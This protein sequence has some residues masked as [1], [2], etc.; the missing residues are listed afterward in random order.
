MADEMI[1]ERRKKGFQQI[2]IGVAL[3]IIVAVAYFFGRGPAPTVTSFAECAQKGFPIL[4]SYPRQ[5]R[6][7]DGKTFREDIGGELEK[8]NLIRV[9][10][11]RPNVSVK[12]PLTVKGV[13]R[14]NWF[15]EASFPIKLLDASGKEVAQGI[16]QAKREWMTTEFV[17]FEAVLTFTI[18][19]VGQGT[20]VLQK[21]NPSGLLENDDVLRIPI[22]FEKAPTGT[23][24]VAKACV[25]S[26]CSGQI[27]ADEEMM[28]TCEFREEY[29]CYKNAK[30]ERQTSGKC[31]WT[32]TAALR[33]CIDR[34]KR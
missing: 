27:C 34:T 18:P 5:C 26:G 4:E 22:T 8:D 13:A 3:L 7:S 14:G 10:D 25:V 21:D 23:P 32:E 29:A 2:G 6:T 12:S 15:F 31:G 30:C 1:S 17:P 20:L 16:A 33:T 9:S 19:T 28:S 11:P 24:E